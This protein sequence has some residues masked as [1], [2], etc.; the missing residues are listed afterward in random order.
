MIKRAE[1]YEEPFR[2]MAMEMGLNVDTDYSGRCMYGETT[3][4]VTYDYPDD[5]KEE[6]RIACE[7]AGMD[8]VGLKVD[9]MG[10]SYVIYV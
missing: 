2:Q 5:V 3:L 1:K 6:F 9:N 7:D 10:M 4:S 8:P